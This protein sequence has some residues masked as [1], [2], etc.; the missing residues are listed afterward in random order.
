MN[1]RTAKCE[2]ETHVWFRCM[3]KRNETKNVYKQ[4]I[5]NKKEK[6]KKDEKILLDLKKINNERK[7]NIWIRIRN[8][9]KDVSSKSVCFL[10]LGPGWS[11]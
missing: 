8:N 1:V 10:H 3:F 2:Q 5:L 9:D 6:Q 4:N 7:R 11:M